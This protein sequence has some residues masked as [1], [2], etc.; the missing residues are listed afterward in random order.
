MIAWAIALGVRLRF[1]GRAANDLRATFE[2]RVRMTGRLA[3]LLVFVDDG[4]C[5][6]RP[7]RAGSADT[8]ATVSLADMLRM[9]IGIASW[10]ELLSSG[11]LI[12]DGD[13][14]LALR[15]PALFRL[16]AIARTRV[17]AIARPAT[18]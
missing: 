9:T 8:R 2:L 13:P 11:R 15:L 1:D 7:A 3:R 17:P 12:L 5:Q 14:F 6:V 18:R 16:P 4:R 10:P